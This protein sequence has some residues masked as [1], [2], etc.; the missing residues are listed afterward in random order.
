MNQRGI[1]KGYFLETVLLL[2]D[3]W[4]YWAKLKNKQIQ[5]NWISL[6]YINVIQMHT[7]IKHCEGNWKIYLYFNQSK[8]TK[9]VEFLVL[10]I[11]DQI[12][13]L[14]APSLSN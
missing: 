3:S 9:E 5:T 1:S 8:Y 7:I 2:T 11:V 14:Q 4:F 10:K 12:N 13:E 6:F